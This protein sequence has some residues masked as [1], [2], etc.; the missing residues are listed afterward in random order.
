MK[1]F[2]TSLILLAVMMIMGGCT[3]DVDKLTGIWEVTDV[4]IDA[5][6][7]RISQETIDKAKEMQR[8]VSLELFADQTMNIISTTNTLP[9]KWSYRPGSG[10]IFVRLDGASL[11]DSI[12]LGK[13]QNGRITNR[14]K[15]SY[16]WMI[17]TYEKD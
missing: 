10:E 12:R 17:T 2:K 11:K 6:T 16:G 7:S 1:T 9:G 8:S 5:D 3:S 13:Y 15:Q 4:T 14:E